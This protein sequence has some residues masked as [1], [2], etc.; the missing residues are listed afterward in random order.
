M[1]KSLGANNYLS[2]EELPR[3][4]ST[5][6]GELTIHF[7]NSEHGELTEHCRPNFLKNSFFNQ[8]EKGDGLLFMTSGYTFSILN[9]I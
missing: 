8:P 5:D 1:Y 7:L 6:A 2:F 4:A 3:T 9:F